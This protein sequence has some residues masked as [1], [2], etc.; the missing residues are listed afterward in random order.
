MINDVYNLVQTIINKNRFGEVTPA[1]FNLFAK[2]AQLKIINEALDDLRR[3]KYRSREGRG[4]EDLT[5]RKEILDDIMS[6][7]SITRKPSGSILAYF[8]LPT[9]FMYEESLW[10]R[11]TTLIPIVSKKKIGLHRG[12]HLVPP[13]EAEPIAEKYANKIYIYPNTIG[14]G[15][16]AGT[17]VLDEVQ[18]YYYAQPTDPKW[19][20]TEVS[21]LAVFN[22]SAA[23]YQDF[24][25]P[26]YIF[27]RVVM[28]ILG[29]VAP[30]LRETEITKLVQAESQE[31]FNKSNV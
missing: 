23:D 27:T 9:D 29:Q 24:T 17:V 1:R 31:E 10:L 4:V 15:D 3:S 7:S 18:L 20:Y 25:I 22:A 11:D 5:A 26:E 28:D 8:T 30:Q 2:S 16:A 12:S 6:K 21:S 19:T 14:V 13:T